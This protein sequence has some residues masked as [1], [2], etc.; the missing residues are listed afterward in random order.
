MRKYVF[1]VDGRANKVQ[2][3][4]AVEM[5]FPKI[6]VLKVNVM[7][8]SR[9]RRRYGRRIIYKPAWKKAIITIPAEQRI[10][11]FEGV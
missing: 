7:H 11:L 5:A 9:K 4:Q 6:R 3:K 1:E 10:D 2:V 8:M